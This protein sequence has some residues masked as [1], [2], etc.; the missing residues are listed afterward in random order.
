MHTPR[1]ERE[2]EEHVE[3]SEPERLD[4]EKVTGDDR[5]GVRTQEVAP[6]ELGASAG[7]RQAGLPEDLGDRCCR[8]AYADAGE[9][10]DDPLVAPARVLAR[11]PQHQRTDLVGDRWSTR[12]PSRIRRPFPHKLAMPTQQGVR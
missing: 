2:E 10:T 12:P 8:D 9:F 5:V 6:A 4:G 1:A 3:A 7:R 11:E